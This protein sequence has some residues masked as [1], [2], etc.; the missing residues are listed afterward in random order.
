MAANNPAPAIATMTLRR[1]VL[2]VL[3]ETLL[4]VVTI[5]EISP[6]DVGPG[7]R[8]DTALRPDCPAPIPLKRAQR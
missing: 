4:V 2:D 3:A 8:A 5:A 1:V 6:L 7:K